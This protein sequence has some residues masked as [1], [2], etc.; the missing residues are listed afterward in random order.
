MVKTLVKKI[1]EATIVLKSNV[2]EDDLERIISQVE[3]TI[4]NNGGTIVRTEDPN[5]RRFSHKINGIKEGYYISLVFNSSSELPNILKRNLAVSDDI[6]RYMIIRKEEIKPGVK[7]PN[8]AQ[9]S[10]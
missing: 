8:T 9:I 3:A 6:L 4:K 7:L 10:R 1:Y 5:R 2:G